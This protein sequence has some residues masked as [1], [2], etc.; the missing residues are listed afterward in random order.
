MICI[1]NRCLEILFTLIFSTFISIPQN[2][3]ISVTPSILPCS[4]V[5]PLAERPTCIR[6]C[7]TRPNYKF[8]SVPQPVAQGQ[9]HTWQCELLVLQFWSLLTTQELPSFGICCIIW[10]ELLTNT[11]LVNVSSSLQTCLPLGY[12]YLVTPWSSPSWEAKTS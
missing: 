4:T 9:L 10:R 12:S 3:P 11:I 1:W 6:S 2:L 7:W 5:S 8:N